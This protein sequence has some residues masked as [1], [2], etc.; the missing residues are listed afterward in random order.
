MMHTYSGALK[1][2]RVGSPSSCLNNMPNEQELLPNPQNPNINPIAPPIARSGAQMSAVLAQHL[3][4]T[5][6]SIIA[7]ASAAP[8]SAPAAMPAPPPFSL[9]TSAAS[10]PSTSVAAVAKN[11]SDKTETIAVHYKSRS[12]AANKPPVYDVLALDSDLPRLQF[13]ARVVEAMGLEHP[14][15]LAYSIHGLTGKKQAQHAFDTESQVEHAIEEVLGHQRRSRSVKK[16]LEIVCLSPTVKEDKTLSSS[17]SPATSP[18]KSLKTKKSLSAKARK[19]SKTIKS[20]KL[21]NSKKRAQDKKKKVALEGACAY[22]Q[23]VVD[24]RSQLQCNSCRGKPFCYVDPETGGHITCTIDMITDWAK[25]HQLDPKGVPLDRPPNFVLFDLKNAHKPDPTSHKSESGSAKASG[26]SSHDPIFIDN[27]FPSPLPASPVPVKPRSSSV[28]DISDD[29]DVSMD[30]VG[31]D[32]S[33]SE[34]D[35]DLEVLDT[36]GTNKVA[37]H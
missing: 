33:D 36:T 12:K 28:I 2:R 37:K 31:S 8:S 20:L 30:S 5:L 23:H 9:T 15:E 10:E 3:A 32:E 1:N 17:P 29:T 6:P 34:S 16:G 13:R 35:S 11:P 22:T 7:P 25:A 24:L 27:N 21:R 26:S 14:V 19:H 4:E 18:S